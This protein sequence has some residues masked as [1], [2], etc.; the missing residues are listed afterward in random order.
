M[1]AAD[2]STAPVAGTLYVVATPIGNLGDMTHR[3]LEV[4]GAVDGILAEDTRHSAGLLQHYGIATPVRSYHEHSDEGLAGQLLERLASGES[5]AL[6]SD[7]GTPLIADPGYKL[8]S[9][10]RAR[11]IP[12][13][14]IPGSCALVA[15]LSVA[16]LPTDRFRFEG[17][18]PAKAQA[19]RKR[20]E[21]LQ[22]ESATLV[23]Y[24]SPHRIEEAL[25][26]LA[27]VLGSERRAVLA[28][29]LTKRFESVLDG[30]LADLYER[31]QT[32][33]NQ[34]RGELVIIVAGCESEQSLDEREAD[35]VLRILLE[36]LPASQAAALAAQI[37]GQR[38]KALYQRALGLKP[39][40]N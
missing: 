21:Q 26:A 34:R 14:P 8:V 30:D 25:E 31:V 12:V 19:R 35:R 11:A 18:L 39:P 17:F 22:G 33:R 9:Q 38:K 13:V 6:I 27:Q 37:T 15:A 4:L 28:R 29:E 10:A 2:A 24:E 32:D 36:A 23:F 16:G 40:A 3:A 7:A 5:L 1:Q 20:L